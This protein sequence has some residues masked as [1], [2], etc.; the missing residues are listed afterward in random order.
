MPEKEKRNAPG[1]ERFNKEVLNSNTRLIS[2]DLCHILALLDHI[3]KHKSQSMAR[4]IS[5]YPTQYADYT[6][7]PTGGSDS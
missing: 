2:Y 3:C 7:V 6:T 5:L 4:T 1:E